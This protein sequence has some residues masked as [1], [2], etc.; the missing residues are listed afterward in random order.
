VPKNPFFTQQEKAYFYELPMIS[1][2]LPGEEKRWQ[3]RIEKLLLDQ[4]AKID[5]EWSKKLGN[6]LLERDREILK[7]KD[8]LRKRVK[9]NCRKKS[10]K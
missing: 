10:G 3:R 6:M 7:L 1:S 5:N 9:G 2:F 8:E 4:K